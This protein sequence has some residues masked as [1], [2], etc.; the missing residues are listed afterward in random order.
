M[1]QREIAG[2]SRFSLACNADLTVDL[3][4]VIAEARQLAASN[5][6]RICE[7]VGDEFRLTEAGKPFARSI[8]AVFDSYL[9]T[10]KGRHSI[11]V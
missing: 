9:A 5:P 10:G 4:P 7:I 3:L 6:D 2:E 11:A 1:A 8:A